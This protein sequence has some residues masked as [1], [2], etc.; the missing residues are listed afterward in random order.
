MEAFKVAYEK[1]FNMKSVFERK[2]DEL[3]Q[4]LENVE[5]NKLKLFLLKEAETDLTQTKLLV[6][7]HIPT[8]FGWRGNK[9]NEISWLS[10]ILYLLNVVFITINTEIIETIIAFPS[11]TYMIDTREEVLNKSNYKG[12]WNITNN[13]ILECIKVLIKFGAEVNTATIL[14]PSKQ[15]RK[16]GVRLTKRIENFEKTS[17]FFA[18]YTRTFNEAKFFLDFMPDGINAVKLFKKQCES[19][20]ELLQTKDE[21]RSTIRDSRRMYFNDLVRIINILECFIH[22]YKFEGHQMLK[23]YNRWYSEIDRIENLLMDIEEQNEEIITQRQRLR[24]NITPPYTPVKNNNYN[25][26]QTNP[27]PYYNKILNKKSYI[28]KLQKKNSKSSKKYSSILNTYNGTKEELNKEIYSQYERRD[29]QG[30]L[31]N[32]NNFKPSILPSYNRSKMIN[33]EIAH[34]GGGVY[35]RK[36]T[37]K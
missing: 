35:K 15:T 28:K 26:S 11:R 13:N 21:A 19:E 5:L 14:K 8:K 25:V 20:Y 32:F 9:Y 2:Q 12:E 18:L 22:D 31:G 10:P 34:L 17:L 27:L 6:N 36:K 16:R 3:K 30:K 1:Y 24:E 7:E 23:E 37:K 29:K 4:I 33:I